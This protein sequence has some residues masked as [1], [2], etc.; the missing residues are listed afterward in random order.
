ME[1]NSRGNEVKR[2]FN[3]LTER[4]DFD[5]NICTPEKGWQQYD[6]TQDA[7]YFGV[8]V[9]AEKRIIKTF[10]EGDIMDVICKDE[11]SY[12]A[13]LKS[14]AECYGNPPP[15]FRIIT[16]EGKQIHLYDER[17]V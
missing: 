6:T 4:Y 9:N 2:G 15:A 1:T 11:N 5:F 13:E 14:M 10:A 12:H 16:D 17:P 7:S 3:P 8:W